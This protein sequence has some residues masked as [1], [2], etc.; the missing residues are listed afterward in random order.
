MAEL[1]LAVPVKLTAA[2]EATVSLAAG[3]A[4]AAVTLS[5]AVPFQLVT[6]AWAS[7]L[8]SPVAWS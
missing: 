7:T 5:A 1:S 2:P 3:A 6:M 4:M 8:P